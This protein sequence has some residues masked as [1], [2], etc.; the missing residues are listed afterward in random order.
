VS[1]NVDREIV[2]QLQNELV[3]KYRAF[4]E[5]TTTR[6]SFFVIPRALVQH[7]RAA[8][9]GISDFVNLL[10]DA[11]NQPHECGFFM[12]VAVY[13]SNYVNDILAF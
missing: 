13:S 9:E 1:R 8:P 5:E 12:G 11:K 2:G 6:P 4:M 7:L 10:Y 3:Q